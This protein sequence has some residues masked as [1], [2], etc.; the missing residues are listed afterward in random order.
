MVK[1]ALVYKPIVNSKKNRA[2]ISTSRVFVMIIVAFL[3]LSLFKILHPHHFHVIANPLKHRGF[4][5]YLRTFL[6][7][8]RLAKTLWRLTRFLQH[9]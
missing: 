3:A 8:T 4:C 7:L 1:D 5:V 6:V 2:T 9:I